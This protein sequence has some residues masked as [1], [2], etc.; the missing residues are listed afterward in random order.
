MITP[1]TTTGTLG[2]AND[3]I[4]I[5]GADVDL[6]LVQTTGTWVGTITAEISLD[7]TNWSSNAMINAQQTNAATLATTWTSNCIMKTSGQLR[8]PY[9]RVKMT[10]YTS[11][12]AN[13]TIVAERLVK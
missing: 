12:T 9:F 3:T 10:P 7:G 5:S 2:A 6:I 4:S 1:S 11:G 8:V 13:I